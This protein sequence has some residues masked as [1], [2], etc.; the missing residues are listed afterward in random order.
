LARP[1]NCSR[2]NERERE[3]LGRRRGTSIGDHNCCVAPVAAVIVPT[4]VPRARS[5]RSAGIEG[6]LRMSC[7]GGEVAQ[8]P[9][10]GD[11]LIELPSRA[12]GRHR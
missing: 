12:G 1:V 5:A 3:Q 2:R 11:S 9:A 8:S 4:T 7:S 10:D 6:E